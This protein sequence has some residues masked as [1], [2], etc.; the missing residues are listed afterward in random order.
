MKSAL[1]LYSLRIRIRA[2]HLHKRALL[3]EFSDRRRDLFLAGVP[4]AINE[5]EILP[6]LALARPRFDFRHVNFITAKRRQRPVKSADPVRDAEHQARAIM[7][8]RR[9]A[10]PPE[11]EE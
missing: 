9:T 3:F 5:E 1:C 7:P 6:R 2:Q 11:H 4:I 10:L 8:G